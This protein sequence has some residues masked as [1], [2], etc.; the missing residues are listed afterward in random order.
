MNCVQ[1][2]SAARAPLRPTGW[3]S[4]KA[5]PHH[6]QQLGREAGEPGVAQ[7]VG[8]AGFFRRRRA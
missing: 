4:S 2:G 3:L 1:I 7:I 6:R 5:D 8:G